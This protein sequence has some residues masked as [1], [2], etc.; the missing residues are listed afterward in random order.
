MKGVVLILTILFSL[1]VTSSLEAGIKGIKICG[2]MPN[3]EVLVKLSDGTLVKNVVTDN[4]GNVLIKELHGEQWVFESTYPNRKRF[5]F[6]ITTTTPVVKSGI[7]QVGC[8]K[9]L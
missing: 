1:V 6:E 9:L 3:V 2:L 8:V 4:N 7:L 5:R